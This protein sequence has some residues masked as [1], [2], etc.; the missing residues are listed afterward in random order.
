MMNFK[1]IP[2][3]DDTWELF[4]R[5][6]LVERGFFVESSPD[7]GPDAGKDILIIEKLK[8]NINEY[9]F[10]WLVSCKHFAKS[11]VAVKEGDEPNILERL[12][13]FRAD[14]FI[15]FYSTI[16]SSGL[17]FRAINSSHLPQIDV[18]YSAWKMLMPVHFRR[19]HK[20]DF[21][22][23]PLRP[24]WLEKSKLRSPSFLG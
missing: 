13:A 4:A 10:R 19:R 23:L 3:N 11:G 6:F 12:T 24:S 16:P 9:R 1:E 18:N 20:R 8:G 5:D 15:G 2:Y 22:N 17:L 7:R 14:G 21:A